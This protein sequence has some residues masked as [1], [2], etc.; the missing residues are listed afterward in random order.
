MTKKL[1]CNTAAQ[2]GGTWGEVPLHTGGRSQ[3]EVRKSDLLV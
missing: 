1:P 2:W 3:G